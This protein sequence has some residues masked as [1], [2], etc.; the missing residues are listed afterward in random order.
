M[1]NTRSTK[2]A[3]LMSVVALVLCFTMLTGTTFAWFTDSV[4]SE[5]NVIKAGNLDIVLEYWNGTEW[6][7]VKGASD[8]LDGDLW[9]PGYVDIAYLRFKNAGSLALK[10]QLGVNIVSET[11]GKTPAGEA[12]TLSDYIY[13][14]VFEGVNGQTGAY[15]N[16]EAA[17]EN[18]TETTLISDGYSKA[19]YLDANSEFV[20]LAM[21]VY[22]PVSVGNEAN[23][24]GTNI[25]EINLGV[26]ILAT[27]YTKEE[28]SFNDQYD[29]DAEFFTAVNTIDG[30]KNAINNGENVILENNLDLTGEALTFTAGE[31]VEIDLNG[32]TLTV[33]NFE[34]QA[35]ADVTVKGGTFVNGVA[36]YPAISV[37]DGGKLTLIDVKVVSENYCNIVTSGSATAAEFVGVEVFGGEC[38]LNNCDIYVEATELRYSNSVFGVGIHDGS[39]VMNGGSITVKSVGSTKEKYDYQSAIFTGGGTEKSITLNNVEINA[40]KLLYAWGGNT[41]VN[42]TDAEGSWTADKIDAR[43]GGTYVIN[44]VN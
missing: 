22:M 35:G 32:K 18:T 6:K 26:E 37:V 14:D 42:T 33:S 24:D 13:Y 5:N 31:N 17:L 34:A 9:E 25:P 15:A 1:T 41:T 30:F 4:T 36:T 40:E 19:N 21:V 20:Y 28:D 44:Y 38:V 7:D 23:H 27:Q 16:R 43:N 3:L 11:D 10:Y 12:I 29:A 8:I 39:L 2:R